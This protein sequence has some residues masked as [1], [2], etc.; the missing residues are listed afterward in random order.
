MMQLHQVGG[1]DGT[2]SV[3]DVRERGVLR[4][5]GRVCR[6]MRDGGL[7]RAV[8]IPRGHDSARARQPKVR[9]WKALGVV[10]TEYHQAA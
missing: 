8:V 4:G 5:A 9:R 3:K 7:D 6:L 2:A 1:A 10:I